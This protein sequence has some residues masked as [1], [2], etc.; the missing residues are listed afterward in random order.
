MNGEAPNIFVRMWSATADFFICWWRE[1]TGPLNRSQHRTYFRALLRRIMLWVPVLV[2]AGV[3]TAALG[4]QFFIGWRARDLAH[5]ALASVEQNNLNLARVQITSARSLRPDDPAVLR[6]LAAIETKIGF[7]GAAQTWRK[8]PANLP[9][10]PDELELRASAMIRGGDDAQFHDALAAL[11]KAGRGGPA[12]VLRAERS[13]SRGNLQQAIIEAREAVKVSDTPAHRLVLLR[14][15]L[16][17][18]A[19]F[20][21]DTSQPTA[22][23]NLV[24][25]REISGLV[26][27][28]QG[29]PEGEVATGLVLR[30]TNPTADEIRRWSEAAW[31]RPAPDNP[32]LLPA[33]AAMISAGQATR[34]EMLNRLK[35]VYASSDPARKVALAA[36]LLA[37]GDAEGALVYASSAEAPRNVRAFVTRAA[38]LATLGQWNDLL[39]LS[40]SAGTAPRSLMLAA[41][42]QA[43]AKLDRGGQAQKCAQ[44]AVRAA[45][46]EGTAVMTLRILDEAGF[47]ATADAEIIALCGDPETGERMFT[48]ARDRFGRG[49]QPASLHAAYER[50]A[51]AVPNAAAVQDY[52]RFDKL[53]SGSAVDP[54]ETA[55]ALAA[56]PTDLN[57]RMTHALALLQAGRAKD[58]MAVFDDFDVFVEQLPPGQ[59]ALAVA[60]FAASGENEKARS[61]VATIDPNL[62]AQGE[63]ALLAPLVLGGAP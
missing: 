4:V 1:A 40:E 37:Q 2:L 29:T 59:K 27:S 49:G 60:I 10:T 39:T 62:L 43:N 21:A 53:L 24:A 31:N 63:F 42:A 46:R 33:A 56:N 45:A 35:A 22:P 13:V 58:A 18:H 38:A 20:L 6:A 61:L 12:A 11:E 32:A 23:E 9:L 36:W 55:A 52:H 14:L 34:E 26:D 5:K 44:D 25:G 15:L 8:L 51:T 57:L 47:R 16:A 50:A 17:R 3:I 54:Q 41:A 7:G 28:L 30:Q 19:R 48:L